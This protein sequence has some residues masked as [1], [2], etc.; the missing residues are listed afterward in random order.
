MCAPDA[1]A[2]APIREG[3]ER[4]TSVDDWDE[5]G[6][7]EGIQH[8][9]WP[10]T[11]DAGKDDVGG[12]LDLAGHRLV[13]DSRSRRLGQPSGSRHPLLT[14]SRPPAAPSHRLRVPAAFLPLPAL[15]VMI[16]HG[17]GSP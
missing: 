10:R 17:T 7:G 9:S 2:H 14:G 6:V 4:N 5:V 12:P 11:V 15:A 8:R 16:R 3:V 1:I 13:H